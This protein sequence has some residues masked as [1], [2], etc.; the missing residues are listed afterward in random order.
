MKIGNNVI[1]SKVLA[2][3]ALIFSALILELTGHKADGL[4]A[5]SVLW[6]IFGD[7]SVKECECSKKEEK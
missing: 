7:W 5:I 3:V 2:L 4:W 1:Q 6:I